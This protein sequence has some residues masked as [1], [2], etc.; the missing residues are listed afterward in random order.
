VVQP[1]RLIEWVDLFW[2]KDRLWFAVALR[3][4]LGALL[5]YAAPECRAP[6][7]VRALGVITVIAAIGLVV[8]G[9]ERMDGFVHWWT[10]R[11][12]TILRVWSVLGV[13]LGAFLIYAGV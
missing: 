5:I 1:K 9:P 8:L 7:A 12:P 2:S 11:S 10:K 3:L 13:L 4:A 6:L